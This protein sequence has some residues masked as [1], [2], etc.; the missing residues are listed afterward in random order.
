MKA[1]GTVVAALVYL[2][3]VI[4]AGVMFGIKAVVL[5]AVACIATAAAAVFTGAVGGEEDDEED[6]EGEDE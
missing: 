3:S 1:F 6:W 2:A 5:V 4:A